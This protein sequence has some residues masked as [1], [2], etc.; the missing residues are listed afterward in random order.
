MYNL[1]ITDERL[2]NMNY[3][4]IIF[5]VNGISDESKELEQSIKRSQNKMP[6]T[7]G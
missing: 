3:A 4:Q 2:L 5:S 6:N 1:P 7:F